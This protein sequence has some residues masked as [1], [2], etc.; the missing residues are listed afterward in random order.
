MAPG[1]PA[2]QLQVQV[3]KDII[4]SS[5][6]DVTEGSFPG[7]LFNDQ[8]AGG[9]TS[10]LQTAAAATKAKRAALIQFIDS[11]IA[12]LEQGLGYVSS[13]SDGGVAKAEGKL[14]LI[15]LLKAFVEHDGKLSGK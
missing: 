5:A 11:R 3:L 14:V 7:P 10:V 12:E 15:K 4:P 13:D 2:T 8:G 9:A 6:Y 1:R